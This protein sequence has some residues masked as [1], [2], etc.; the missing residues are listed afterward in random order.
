[1]LINRLKLSAISAIKA[2]SALQ[3]RRQRYTNQTQNL[4][5]VPSSNSDLLIV[6][7]N[8]LT[9]VCT[10]TVDRVD[11]SPQQLRCMRTVPHQF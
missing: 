4:K 3:S 8:I 2:I 1:M 6:Y 10:G 5:E 11:F 7:R 9:Q